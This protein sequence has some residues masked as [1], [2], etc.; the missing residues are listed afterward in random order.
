M[1]LPDPI[2]VAAN[3]PTPQLIFTKTKF[4]GYGSEMVDTAG[5]GYTVVITHT[6]GKAANRHYVKMTKK[7]NAVN[8][9]SGLTQPKTA[10][11]SL[12]FTHPDFGF[13]SADMIALVQALFDTVLDSEVTV[14]KL[15]QNQS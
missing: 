13:T 14:A 11:V 8:P 15:L 4:D 12:S 2:T 9:Y 3:A 10:A 6:P 1:A 5:N 7:V